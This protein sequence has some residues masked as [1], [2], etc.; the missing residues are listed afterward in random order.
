MFNPDPG[1]TTGQARALPLLFT[2]PL[3]SA[4]GR[5]GVSKGAHVAARLKQP[6]HTIRPCAKA[7]RT[8]LSC[9]LQ[10]P[11]GC[12]LFIKRREA[13]VQPRRSNRK[14]SWRIE[15]R[16]ENLHLIGDVGRLILARRVFRAL[17]IPSRRRRLPISRS[18]FTHITQCDGK[19]VSDPAFPCRTKIP[20]RCAGG[21]GVSAFGLGACESETCMQETRLIFCGSVMVRRPQIETGLANR[22]PRRLT[23]EFGDWIRGCGV[24]G[25]SRGRG[26]QAKD[27]RTWVRERVLVRAL[28][29]WCLSTLA[30]ASAMIS[31][32]LSA[33]RRTPAFQPLP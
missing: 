3:T 32:G 27:P 29:A 6:C 20:R 14:K 1:L 2:Q 23:R 26:R 10:F 13:V 17:G 25:V 9:P 31:T 24:F 18:I 33:P 15:S 11:L 22:P 30:L 8:Q 28:Q 7:N 16:S 5:P 19:H 4:A 12:P 21:L